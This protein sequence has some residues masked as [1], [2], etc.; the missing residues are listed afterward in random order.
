MLGKQSNPFDLNQASGAD[1]PAQPSQITSAPP[2]IRSRWFLIGLTICCVFGGISGLAFWWLTTPPPSPDCGKI[3]PLSPDMERLHCVQQAA[4]SGEL[5]KILAGLEL[6]GQWTPD[7]PLYGEAQRLIAEWSEPVLTAARRK[8]EESDLRG[9]VELASRIPRSSPL[10][11]EAQ[12][13]IAEWKRYWQKGEAIA[14][15]ADQALKNQN[16]DLAEQQ[17]WLLREFSQ[18]YWRLERATALS[19]RLS[20]E[21]QGRRYL[22]QATEVARL[23][24]PE[25]L[26]TAIAL[27]SRMDAKTYGWS[28]A[29]P[30]LKQWSETLLS[31]GF[32]HW[33]KGDLSEAMVLA[34][35]VS[36]IPS[37]LR[38]LKS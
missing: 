20:V 7:H 13:A 32:S 2:V 27:I 12:G 26:G 31:L 30:M 19:Q 5:P 23:G 24:Q 21:Q 4:R 18:D 16:W 35:W 34:Q 38:R 14:A 15:A 37:W 17:I 9:A 29:Q 25:Q 36:P 11:R 28:D 10:Y 22:A 1:D 6:L 8:V 33:L 3:S